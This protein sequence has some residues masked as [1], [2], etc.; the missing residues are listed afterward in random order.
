MQV[1][2]VFLYDGEH[3]DLR[4]VF[5]SREEAV[6]YVRSC[7][8]FQQGWYQWCVLA[9]ALGQELDVFSPVEWVE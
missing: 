5:A 9:S 7:Y 6:E 1:F 4:G 2:S 3:R 8:D